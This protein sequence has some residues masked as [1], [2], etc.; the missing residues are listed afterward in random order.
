MPAGLRHGQW[1]DMVLTIIGSDHA[2]YSTTL[3]LWTERLQVRTKIVKAR[4]SIF[5]GLGRAEAMAPR[6]GSSDALP[7]RQPSA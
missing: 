6:D 3:S 7:A 2:E 5:A 1:L 4:T